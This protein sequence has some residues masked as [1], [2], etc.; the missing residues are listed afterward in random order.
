LN[1]QT[2]AQQI[3]WRFPTRIAFRFIFCY[4]ALYCL[5]IFAGELQ[6]FQYL[7]SGRLTDS[8][9]DPFWHHVVPWVGKH[10]L[11]LST[12]I[13]IFSNGSGDTTYDYVL[14]LCE[15]FLAGVATVVWSLLDRKRPNYRVLH[16]WL[17]FVVRLALAT[18]L[19]FYGMDKLIPVQFGSLTL[20]RLSQ[21]VGGLSPMGMLWTFMAASKPYTIFSGFAEV[22]AGVL[23]LVPQ[24]TMLGALITLGAMTNVFAL[25]MS[26]DVPVKLG[27]L[28]YLLMAMFLLA[29]ETRRLMNVFVL[30]RPAAPRVSV[31]LSNRRWIDQGALILSA[32][33]GIVCLPLLTHFSLQRYSRQNPPATDRSPL[34][35][36]W[37]VDEFTVSGTAGNPVPGN[38]TRAFL[39]PTLAAV[40]NVAPGQDRWTE[41]IFQTPTTANIIL[42]N[43]FLDYVTLALDAQKQTAAISDDSDPAWK[44][45]FAYQRTGEQLGM[46]GSINGN[47]VTLKLHRLDD[48]Q[49]ILT[50]RG[51]H[52]INEYPF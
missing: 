29:P 18:Q 11:H 32:L 4:L 26:Y 3:N 9:I 28:H 52:W 19:F 23:L 48:S 22:L 50:S 1:E 10:L 46:Q 25:D 8:F 37:V 42:G 40:M 15:L 35:G 20:A 34:Y 38:S 49:M 5:Y 24:L 36:V 51:F 16:E 44:C 33:V 13:T 30:N 2:D 47:P 12:D 45:D 17:R 14:I 41:L 21:R 31:P 6:F 7:A 43:G 27:S 39:T